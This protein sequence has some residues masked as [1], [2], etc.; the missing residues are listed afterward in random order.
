MHCAGFWELGHKLFC[1]TAETF[2]A[3]FL[4]GDILK[5][6]LAAAITRSLA[7]ARPQ[8]ILSRA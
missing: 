7:R 2:P 8:A 3:V 6:V 5:A 4:P 1:S